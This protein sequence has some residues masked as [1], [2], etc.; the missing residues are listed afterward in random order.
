MKTLKNKNIRTFTRILFPRIVAILVLLGLGAGHAFDCITM[1]STACKLSS[2]SSNIAYIEQLAATTPVGWSEERER[3]YNEAIN[4]R[5]DLINSS[6]RIVA[7]FAQANNWQRCGQLILSL[8]V[9]ALLLYSGVR[10]IPSSIRCIKRM[11]KE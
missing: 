2:I 6:D 9:S 10:F 5:N 4:K 11:T 3:D 1:L 8:L 7:N